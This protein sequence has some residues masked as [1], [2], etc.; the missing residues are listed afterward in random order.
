MA[1]LIFQSTH[2]SWGATSTKI[3]IYDGLKISIHA[4]IVGCDS[5]SSL[6]F[7]SYWYF[8][9]R[10]H[11]GVRRNWKWNTWMLKE[12][13]STHPSWGAT[14]GLWVSKRRQ[15]N[16]NP[17]THR[18][19]RQCFCYVHFAEIDISIHAPIVGCDYDALSKPSKR[20]MISIHA[21]IVGS[22]LIKTAVMDASIVISIHAPIVGCDNEGTLMS[23]STNISIHAP[24]VGCDNLNLYRVFF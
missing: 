4:P 3:K 8:N 20:Q 23:M 24:I 16:F 15:R 12:F 5:T 13:Q 21:P 9:P 14:A 10:T 6:G 11:R 7:Y 1:T 17:R 22:D 18:G 2:P 19:V